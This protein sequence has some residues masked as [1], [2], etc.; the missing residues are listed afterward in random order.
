MGGIFIFIKTASKLRYHTRAL[1]DKYGKLNIYNAKNL[2][3]LKP[4][5]ENFPEW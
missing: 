5:E 1:L 3:V 2:A 4:D